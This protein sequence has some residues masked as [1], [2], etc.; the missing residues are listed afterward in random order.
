VMRDVAVGR[1]ERHGGEEGREERGGEERGGEETQRITPMVSTKYSFK[2][3]TTASHVK[4]EYYCI[5]ASTI[6]ATTSWF[7]NLETRPQYCTIRTQLDRHRSDNLA[8]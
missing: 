7:I 6:I 3:L 1:N 8:G 4:F 2:Y 5:T